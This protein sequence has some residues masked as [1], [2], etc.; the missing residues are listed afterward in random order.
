MIKNNI[1]TVVIGRSLAPALN[2]AIGTTVTAPAR[3]N[4]ISVEISTFN[5][6]ISKF[7]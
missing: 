5:N 1:P 2:K 6:V 7:E 4:K 3:N